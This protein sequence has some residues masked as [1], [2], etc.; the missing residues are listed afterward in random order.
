MIYGIGIDIIEIA[1][2]DQAASNPRFIDR[3]LTV[4]EQADYHQLNTRSR[5]VEFLAGRWAAKEAYA[6]A[7]GTGIGSQ[8]SWLDISLSYAPS[9]Q[10]T[11]QSP[12][13]KGATFLSI[14]HSRHYAVAQVV[15]EENTRI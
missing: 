11:I 6:K 4:S 13:F 8:C 2:I 3:L 14:S 5:Q 10:V 7:L 9:G 15:L 12:H 1:R